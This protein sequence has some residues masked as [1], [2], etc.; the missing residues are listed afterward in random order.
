MGT[1][2]AMLPLATELLDYGVAARPMEESGVSGDMYAVLPIARG[3]LMAV[4][5]G[6][7]HGADAAR[8]ARMALVTIEEAL[9]RSLAALIEDC[10][11]ALRPTR[12][13]AMILVVLDRFDREMSWCSV[14]NVDG[15]VLRPGDK[16]VLDKEMILMRG[17]IVGHRLPPPRGDPLETGGGG[18]MSGYAD[19]ENRYR[20]TLVACL[21]HEGAEAPLVEA[22]DLGKSA[23]A[24]GRSLLG[25]VSIHH[26]TMGSLADALKQ[27]DAENGF[28]RAEERR[29]A[30]DERRG[31]T[32]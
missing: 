14:G 17:G 32:S 3:S 25:V 5:D 31:K 26:R 21:D 29:E 24:D 20:Q 8:A 19:F 10:H 22:M 6:L 18:A 13:A 2:N 11:E 27:A 15:V 1:L 23:L 30:A 9:E 28:T 4:V 12:G 16:G 7:G